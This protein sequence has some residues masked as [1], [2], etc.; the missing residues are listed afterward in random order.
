VI[1]DSSRLPL[2][3]FAVCHCPPDQLGLLSDELLECQVR[4]DAA[5][6]SGQGRSR[7]EEEASGAARGLPAVTV[8]GAPTHR[9]E[10]LIQ[11]AAAAA[12]GG[13]GACECVPTLGEPELLLAALVAGGSAAEAEA[14]LWEAVRSAAAGVDAQFGAEVINKQSSIRRSVTR[15]SS[16]SSSSSSSSNAG[17][18]SFS[19]LQR[20]LTVGAASQLLLALAPHADEVAQ[21]RSTLNGGER[22]AVAR[23]RLVAMRVSEITSAA[24]RLRAAGS[25]SEAEA[26]ATDGAERCLQRLRQA[27]ENRRLT[28]PRRRLKVESGPDPDKSFEGD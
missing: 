5:S 13:R 27:D 25:L 12:A 16:S 22:P 18:L 4:L 14:R 6:T 10:Q 26:A 24:Q 2:L 21:A 28:K 1:A 9:S 15:Q 11:A 3:A 17:A 7:G 8:A 20:L 19:H 23:R